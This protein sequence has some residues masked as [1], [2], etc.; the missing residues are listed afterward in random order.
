MLEREMVTRITY[1]NVADRPR[2]DCKAKKKAKPGQRQLALCGKTRCIYI[3][4]LGFRVRRLG[5]LSGSRTRKRGLL[6][7]RSAIESPIFSVRLRVKV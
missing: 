3:E 7:G 6:I 1:F 4:G 2:K 5:I